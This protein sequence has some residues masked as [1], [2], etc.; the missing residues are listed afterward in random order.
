MTS[1]EPAPSTRGLSWLYLIA[2]AIGLVASAAL[3]I[4]K[5]AKLGDPEYIPSCSF[6]P[7]LTCGDVMDSQQAS[8]FGF[9]NPLIGIAAFAVVVTVGVVSLAGFRAPRWFWLGM[10][11]GTTFGVVFVHWLIYAS[12]YQIGALCPYCMVVWAVT[13][14]I[15]WYTTLHNLTHGH[16]SAGRP[17]ATGLARF[18]SLLLVLWFLIIVVLILIR[19]WNYWSTLL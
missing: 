16:F 9:P 11:L 4:E 13:I 14:P 18:H 17:A 3:T 15:F 10:Q 12:L 19:F 1:A 2:G 7:V 5:I 6:N 8:A